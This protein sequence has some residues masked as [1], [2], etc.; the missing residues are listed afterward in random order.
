[1]A[2]ERIENLSGILGLIERA[3]NRLPHP[4][5]IFVLLTFIVM[6]LSWLFQGVSMVD[7]KGRT[8]VVQSLVSADGL[9]LAAEKLQ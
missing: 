4:V 8:L 3:G 7:P 6:L 2:K 5:T 1:M 9:I